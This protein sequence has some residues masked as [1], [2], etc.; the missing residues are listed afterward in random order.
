MKTKNI[1]KY[2]L[3]G[4]IAILIF[5]IALI[6]YIL[7]LKNQKMEST[8]I[9]N[10]PYSEECKALSDDLH[11]LNIS[12]PFEMYVNYDAENNLLDISFDGGFEEAQRI[13]YYLEKKYYQNLIIL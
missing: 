11:T 1:K 6:L 3:I 8:D 13:A 12:Y 9:E 7:H 5:G 2:I 10:N 4:I